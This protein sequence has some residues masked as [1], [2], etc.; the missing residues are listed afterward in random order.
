MAKV[1]YAQGRYWD[2]QGMCARVDLEELTKEEQ[3][4]YHLRLLAEAFVIRGTRNLSMCQALT[5]QS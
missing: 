3:P 1:H 4:T 5:R 2:A